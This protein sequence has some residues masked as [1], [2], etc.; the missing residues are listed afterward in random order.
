MYVG[1][2][3]VDSLLRVL[4]EVESVPPRRAEE[5][6]FADS[7]MQKMALLSSEPLTSDSP[8]LFGSR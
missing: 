4:Q 3:M 8:P 6:F 7:R 1:C 5:V 2:G